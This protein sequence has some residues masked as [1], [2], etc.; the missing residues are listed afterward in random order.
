[1]S[2]NSK[3]E[4]PEL[5]E[6]RWNKLNLLQEAYPTFEPFLDDMM[7]ELGFFADEVQQDIGDFLENGPQYL[8]VQA[9]RSQAKTTITAIFAV[10]CL[11][12][13][14][15]HR[16]LIV[17]AGDRQATEI[18][19]LIVRL[20]LNVDILACMRPDRMAGD[21]TSTE[22]F[23]V[24]HSLKGMD[25]SPSVACMGITANLQGAR[26]DL[27]IADDVESGKN[28]RTAVQRAQLLHITKDFTSINQSGRIIYLGTPQSIESI[29]N[30]LPGRGFAVRVW[31]GRY[32]NEKMRALYGDTLAPM[33]TA[34]IARNEMLTTGAGLDGLQGQATSPRIVSEEALIK[35]EL[36]QGPAYFQLQHMLLTA[37][38]D[39]LRYPL[40]SENLVVMRLP[41]N[42][43]PLTVTRGFGAKAIF[44]VCNRKYPV[45]T[46][47]DP[48]HTGHA[49]MTSTVLYVDPAGGGLNADET[50]WACLGLLNSNLFLRGVGGVPGGYD[51]KNLQAIADLVVKYRPTL[52]KIE[53]NFGYGAFAAILTPIIKTTCEHHSIPMPGIE[54]DY[55]N[56]QKEIRIIETLEPIM[57]RGA[58]VINEDIFE[59]EAQS[60]QRYDIRLRDTYSF[61]FQLTKVTRD[62][63]ALLHD[64]R[65]D[66]VAG[67]CAHYQKALAVDQQ[68][69]IKASEKAAYEEM[70]ANPL[71]RDNY[72][73]PKRTTS[74]LP[75][76]GL[77][78][79][80]NHK[81]IKRI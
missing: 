80:F 66:A 61:F 59:E 13:D 46:A 58:L 68:K 11:I 5:A 12:H 25:K 50:G 72:V 14:P 19:T 78:N 26:A 18:S 20:I 6:I 42:H 62:P 49:K 48:G 55:T 73:K 9:Q 34:A 28:S 30:T 31:P 35:K 39:L 75:K 22:A 56:S 21:K 52:V 41:D 47:L 24:H 1:M 76:R 2:E 43:A 16:V 45:S 74:M 8:M 54:E 79:V 32:P 29:Y 40:K 44:E 77:S 33:I 71:G 27:L 64:D 7:E 69:A 4:S 38:T 17:S 10:W 65:L 70:M 57:G 36:D 53:K 60:L 23:D 63:G 3:R 15:T 67:A 37:M 51:P 81:R